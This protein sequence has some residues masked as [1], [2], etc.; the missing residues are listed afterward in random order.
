[1]MTAASIPAGA[2]GGYGVYLHSR[3]VAPEQGDYYLGPDGAPI[4]AAG[5]WLTSP[6]ARARVGIGE[7]PMV[8]PDDLRALMEGRRPN[9]DGWLRPAGPDGSRAGG[10]DLTFSAPKSVSVVWAISDRQGREAIERAQREAV[11]SAV[12]YSAGACR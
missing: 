3:T 2:A 5:R 11:A 4:E 8:A 10:L 7:D 12:A 6:R 9:G 1:M